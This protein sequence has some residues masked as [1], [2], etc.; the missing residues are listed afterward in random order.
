MEGPDGD[1]QVVSYAHNECGQ[2]TAQLG[3]VGLPLM[4]PMAAVA[5]WLWS[6]R[7]TGTCGH[8]GRGCGDLQLRNDATGTL[9]L[10]W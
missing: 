10:L 8:R 1:T 3:L 2:P 7:A 4:V 9:P 6:A 5:A